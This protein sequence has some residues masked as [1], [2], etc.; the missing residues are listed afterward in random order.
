MLLHLLE[1]CQDGVAVAV[2]AV[3][4]SLVSIVEVVVSPVRCGFLLLWLS[5]GVAVVVVVSGRLLVSQIV[6]VVA[7]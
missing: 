2:V 6:G 5:Q 4:C 7:V 3:P 1:L